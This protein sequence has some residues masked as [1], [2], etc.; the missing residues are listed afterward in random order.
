[1]FVG[2]LISTIGS[3]MIFP[4]LMIFVSERLGLPRAASASLLTINS[5]AILFSSILGGPIVDRFGRKWVMVIGL[6]LNGL[7]Y[8]FY[9]QANTYVFFG[10]LMA[11][12]GIVNPLYRIGSDA[13]LADLVLPE[14]RID[15]YAL[16]RLSHNL[17]IA[18]GPT[19]GG[20]LA[21]ASYDAAFLCAASGMLI[22]S[23]LLLLRARETLPEADS[24]LP[25]PR[26]ENPLVSYEPILR[27]RSFL[28]FIWIFTL[29]QACAVLIWTLLPVHAKEAYHVTERVYGFIPT[30]NA[31]MVVTLQLL[32]T[33]VT[34]HFLPMPVMAAGAFLY[35]LSNGGVA[36]SSSFLGFWV[37]M[38]VMTL[39]E[40]IIMPT[41]ST[42]V[43][44][45]APAN[46]RG[47]YMSLYGLAWGAAS[48]IAPVMGGLLNDW[49]SPQ[50]T[51][52]GGLA[53][54]L[55]ATLSFILLSRQQHKLA[56]SAQLSSSDK[57]GL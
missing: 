41:S 20:F 40:L 48:G 12:S 2:Y 4:F 57:A 11:L 1:M 31:L 9:S 22:Y 17:G 30:T 6:L 5:A 37:C 34:R 55:I 52:L 42:Y 33:R 13:M 8:L 50:A 53:V 47:R 27:D 39:G 24:N 29:V 7:V 18:I 25:R 36:L 43:A 45:L 15:A 28:R 35:A 23:L 19:I 14:K 56:Q 32:I 21:A 3:S 10:V 49:I 54:G 38:V 44:N 46:M 26:L 51:W 16:I